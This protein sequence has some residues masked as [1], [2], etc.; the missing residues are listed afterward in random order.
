MEEQ[1]K[2][3]YNYNSP[4]DQQYK[5]EMHQL[6]LFLMIT[7]IYYNDIKKGKNIEEIIEK[8]LFD[9]SPTL[10]NETIIEAIIYAYEKLKLANVKVSPLNDPKILSKIK[11]M[12]KRD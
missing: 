5:N 12:K 6:K 4:I 9:F 8:A 1:N 2:T 3:T 11:E 7:G 10:S